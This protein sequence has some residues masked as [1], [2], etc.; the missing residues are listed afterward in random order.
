MKRSK[1]VLFAVLAAL[2][3]LVSFSCDFPDYQL[4]YTLGTPTLPGG[5]QVAVPYT[6][7]NSGYED[8]ESVSIYIEV[9]TNAGNAYDWTY[10]ENLY[11]GES[12]SGT[13]YLYVSGTPTVVTSHFVSAVRWDESDDDGWF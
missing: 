5:D 1:Y 4:D 9:Y 11:A 2:T 7:V 6:I 13:L 12:T 8:L 10:S 3:I